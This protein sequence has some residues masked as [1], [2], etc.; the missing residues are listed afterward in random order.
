MR[1]NA[2]QRKGHLALKS[3]LLLAV[4]AVLATGVNLA[5]P[6]RLPWV[7][8]WSHRVESKALELGIRVAN[9]EQAKR[10]V[11]EAAGY[12]FDAR[13]LEVFAE[14]HLPMALSLP[15][16]TFEETFGAYAGM[17]IPDQEL[18]VYCSGVVC[19]ESLLVCKSL[20]DYGF[21]NLVLFAGGFE[22]WE[23]AGHAVETGY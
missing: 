7:E 2:G 8:D 6:D 9:V 23:A 22:Q 17:L 16:D 11:D 12:I 15:S 20:L 1:A 13:H 10:L 18:L 19:D 14:G 21:T 4:A 5:R 3:A